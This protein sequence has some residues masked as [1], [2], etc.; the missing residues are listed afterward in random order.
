M[1]KSLR[2]ID[3]SEMIMYNY[4]YGRIV[5]KGLDYIVVDCGGVGYHVFV[6]RS[7]DFKKDNIFWKILKYFFKVLKIF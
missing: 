5:E 3:N 2:F 7:D 1:S 4:L 6:S